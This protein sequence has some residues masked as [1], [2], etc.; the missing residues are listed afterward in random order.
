V[1]SR[2]TTILILYSYSSNRYLANKGTIFVIHGCTSSSP[3]TG[4]WNASRNQTKHNI[5]IRLICTHVVLAPMECLHVMF[6]DELDTHTTQANTSYNTSKHVIQHKQTRH[7]TQANTSYN[8]S[9]HIIQHK[10]TRHTTQANTSY[11]TSKHV[12][13]HKQT[14]HATQANTSYN[15]SKHVIQHKQTRHTTQAN[16]SYNTSKHVTS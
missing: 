2:Q 4:K 12:I 10:Q 5:Q 6:Y 9:K 16:T 8:T 13:Q 1:E 11:N 3:S 14:R 7:T 15:T